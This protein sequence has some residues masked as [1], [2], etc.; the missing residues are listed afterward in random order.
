[1]WRVRSFK[2]LLLLSLYK[3][4]LHKGVTY[5]SDIVPPP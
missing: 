5:T 4:A 2:G 3:E 1:M